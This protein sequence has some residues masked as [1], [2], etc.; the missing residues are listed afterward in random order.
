MFGGVVPLADDPTEA[1]SGAYWLPYFEVTD[2][3]TV[4]AQAEELGGTVRL[5]AA[6]VEGVGRIA[7]LADPY[8][9]R[10]AVIKTAPQSA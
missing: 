1:E 8:G 9:A 5:A 3:D 4:V 10:F 7:R 6:D 2:V